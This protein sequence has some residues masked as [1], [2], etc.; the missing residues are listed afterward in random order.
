MKRPVA[1]GLAF[2]LCL[3]S[4]AHAGNTV[5]AVS[6]AD[7]RIEVFWARTAGA[8]D[9]GVYH[10]WQS[11]TGW[12][13]WRVYQPAPDVD[14]AVVAGRDLLGRVFAAWLS[15]GS[16][17][18]AGSDSPGAGLLAPRR[19]DTSGLRTLEMATN[20]DG[21]VELFALD[22]QGRAWSVPQSA[23]GSWDWGPS[24]FLDGH[25]LKQI[26]PVRYRDGRI[27]LA[28][29]GG[30]G[31][32]YVT[33]QNGP[34]LG[35]G[36]WTGLSGHDVVSV[37]AGANADQ[38][39]EVAA[40]GKDGVL[41]HRFEGPAGWSEWTSLRGSGLS[42]RAVTAQD[43]DQRM[44]TFVLHGGVVAHTWQT[45]ANGVWRDQPTDLSGFSPVSAFAVAQHVDDGRLAVVAATSAGAVAYARQLA[46]N[47]A[48]SDWQA[49]PS[50]AS[51][52]APA[53]P[54]TAPSNPGVPVGLGLA[55]ADRWGLDQGREPFDF[56]VTFTG[57][58]V[59]G[60]GTTGATTFSVTGHQRLSQGGAFAVTAQAN[61]LRSGSWDVTATPAPGLLTFWNIRTCAGVV[62]PKLALVFARDQLTG[63]TRCD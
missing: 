32:V 26:S 4:G 29:L 2:V 27:A 43:A 1:S 39:L 50:V 46:P 15:N 35:W 8:G 3:G 56:D 12:A 23:V 40:V 5:A 7:G 16:I 59:S 13:T 44:E 55:Y 54:S 49:L 20:E 33:S 42:G 19:L 11:Q 21:R 25:D 28:A 22:G 17:W 62:V 52:A 24:R 36:A 37:A 30:D 63:Q 48:F 18:F 10:S 60:A 34:N 31:Q 14:G 58:W 61:G 38:R 9:S 51:A 57:H 41:Y 45:A 47:T 6:S 53:P